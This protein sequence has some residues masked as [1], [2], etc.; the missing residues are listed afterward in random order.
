MKNDRKVINNE[1]VSMC[2]NAVIKV[3]AKIC[4]ES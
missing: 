4:L 3:L 1:F 2:S